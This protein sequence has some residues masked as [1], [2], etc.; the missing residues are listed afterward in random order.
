MDNG[1]A[2]ELPLSCIWLNMMMAV[3][4]PLTLN[5]TLDTVTVLLI[6]AAF[7]VGG[8]SKG[9]IGFGLPIIVV[10]LLSIIVPINIAIALN[11]MPP[12]ILN[13]W[14][15]TH[16]ASIVRN[17][18]RF[19]PVLAGFIGGAAI[20]AYLLS[21]LDPALVLGIVGATVLLFCL[22]TLIGKTGNIPPEKAKKFGLL[23]G[24][25]GGVMGA[26]TS[27]SG[28]AFI[29][30]LVA[31]GLKKDDFVASLGLLFI[32]SSLSLIT[33]FTAVGLIDQTFIP[34]ALACTAATALGMTCG[35]LVRKHLDQQKFQRAVVVMLSILALNLL[36]RAIF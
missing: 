6:F 36:R 16:K 23:S 7:Y 32:F 33:A 30:Y 3:P 22:S 21:G 34:L 20:G 9:A 13:I 8:L 28:P 35:Q 1:A 11:V 17:V 5:G 10:S 25:V 29:T 26:L 31:L 18:G 12:L 4:E 19:W 2:L 24:L 14:Q 15:A 27:I